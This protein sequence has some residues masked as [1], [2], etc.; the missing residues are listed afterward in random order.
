MNQKQKFKSGWTSPFL[1]SFSLRPGGTGRA[2]R[3]GAGTEVSVRRR[4]NLMAGRYR[5]EYAEQL[6]DG[7][8]LIQVSGPLSREPRWRTIREADVKS[9]HRPRPARG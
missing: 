1:K 9:V 4:P 3:V 6:A 8:L 5:V 7:T 2:F